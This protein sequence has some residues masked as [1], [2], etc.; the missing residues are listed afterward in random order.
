MNIGLLII[1]AISFIGLIAAIG[2]GA[3]LEQRIR[4]LEAEKRRKK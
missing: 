3:T 2:Y 4:D 1:A